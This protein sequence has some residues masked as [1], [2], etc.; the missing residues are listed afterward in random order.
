MRNVSFRV[1]LVPV[2]V[3]IT[4]PESFAAGASAAKQIGLHHVIDVREIAALLSVAIDGRLFTRQHLAAKD[5]QHAGVMRGGILVWTEHVEVTQGH[6]LEIVH[7]R[8]GGHVLLAGQLR[9]SIRRNRAEL[10]VLVLGQCWSIAV[11]GG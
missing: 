1:T 8:E 6:R 7:A 10:H 4:S 5:G 3:L 9:N 2:A 11:S